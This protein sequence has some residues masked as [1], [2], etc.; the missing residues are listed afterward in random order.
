M[1]MKAIEKEKALAPS[2]KK[3]KTKALLQL[4]RA[5]VL[6][7]ISDSEVKRRAELMYR[8]LPWWKRSWLRFKFTFVW[9]RVKISRIVNRGSDTN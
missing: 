7:Q 2:E 4:I 5:G 3:R 1:E 9:L 6:R 8:S